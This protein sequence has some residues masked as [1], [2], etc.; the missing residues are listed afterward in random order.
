MSKTSHISKYFSSLKSV[1]FIM[2]GT[3]KEQKI[4][5]EMSTKEGQRRASETS[6]LLEGIKDSLEEHKATQ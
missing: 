5:G 3:S 6:F 2:K 4:S 1:K